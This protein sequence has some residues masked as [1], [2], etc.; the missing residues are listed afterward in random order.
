MARSGG[1]EQ[2][3]DRILHAAE[4]VVLRDGVVRLT[5]E[6][7][8][9]EA[10][11]SKGGVLY[12][13]PSRDALVAAMVA[14]LSDA[15]DASLAAREDPEHRQGSFTRA[16]LFATVGDV[17][18]PDPESERIDR[19]GAALIAGVAADP[20]LL[21][22]LRARFA[23]WQESLVADGLPPA[24]ATVVRL[25]ADGLWL[26]ELFGLGPLPPDLR[27]DVVAELGRLA[28]AER[29]AETQAEVEPETESKAHAHIQSEI[30][31]LGERDR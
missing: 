16:Y 30:P 23:A 15:F 5:L 17:E 1:G 9:A 11:C 25:A 29:V 21:E 4:E 26:V 12:H 14:R 20:K 18:G 10:G 8:A 27:A 13:F 7:A 22:P 3:R 31:P 24:L 6:A 19:L 28:G 2:T